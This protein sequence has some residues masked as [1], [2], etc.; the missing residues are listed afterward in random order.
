MQ[1]QLFESP[2]TPTPNKAPQKK[3]RKPG[4]ENIEATRGEQH[5]RRSDG[6]EQLVCASSRL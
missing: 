5:Q 6:A 2:H 3:E 1:Q 4:V